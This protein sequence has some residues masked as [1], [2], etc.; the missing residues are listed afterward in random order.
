MMELTPDTSVEGYRLSAYQKNLWSLQQ[1]A[2][3][4]P[5]NAF[6]ASRIE[7][8]LN[9]RLLQ[10]ALEE[11][12]RR[13]EILRTRFIRPAGI[14]TPFQIVTDAP[15][16]SWSFVDWTAIDSDQQELKIAEQSIQHRARHFDLVSGPVVDV[17]LIKCSEYLH[18]LLFSIP[19]LCADAVTIAN[20]NEELARLYGAHP[21][22]SEEPTQYADFA[23]WQQ[24]LFEADDQ[25]AKA[26]MTHWRDVQ[27]CVSLLALPFELPK[28]PTWQFSPDSIQIDLSDGASKIVLLAE[29]EQ[30]S[31]SA[32]LFACLHAVI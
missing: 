1:I 22:Q 8:H 3:N 23:E 5:F 11:L 9:A 6:G 17:T 14:R 24:E 29:Q 16:F 26:G 19:S 10:Q 7:G 28:V 15:E 27:D 18:V 13:H 25:D 20:F 31:V 2:D 12:V 21:Q 4:Q 30:T 32:V